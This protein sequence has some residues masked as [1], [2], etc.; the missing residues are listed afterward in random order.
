M[1]FLI[2]AAVIVFVVVEVTAPPPPPPSR[3]PRPTRPPKGKKCST[4]EDC[5]AGECC[6]DVRKFRKGFCQKLATEGKRCNL[7]DE[8]FRNRY[9]HHCPCAEGL[10]C[11]A[12]KK[13][14]DPRGNEI[15]INERCVSPTSTS[16]EPEPET[17][18]PEEGGE[19]EE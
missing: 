5:E 3:P 16:E 8:M 1:K 2:F 19:A 14:K 10:T 13:I 18:A 4:A 12:E 15:R 9:I 7:E 17:E 11:E 6:V